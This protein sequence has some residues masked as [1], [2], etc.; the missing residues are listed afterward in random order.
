MNNLHLLKN[1]SNKNNSKGFYVALGICLIAI[2]VAAWTTYDSVVNY[3][4]PNTDSA[5]STQ[6]TNQTASGIRVIAGDTQSSAKPVSSVP[7]SSRPESRASSKISS[8]APAKQTQAP[9]LTFL[10]PVGKTVTVKFSGENPIYSKTL[11]DWRV[12]TGVDLS[13]KQ[14]DPVKASADGTVKD[15]YADDAFGNTVVITHGDIEAYYCGLGQTS[16]KKGE[17]VKQ[18]QQIGTV[19]VVPCESADVSHLHFAMKQSGKFIDPLTV[20]K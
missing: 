20:L 3:S 4:S 19:G 9:A 7:A 10:Y 15:V 12:H 2:G 1:R 18:S 8:S 5:S 16:V 14:G 17:K 13:A 11:K 6:Q